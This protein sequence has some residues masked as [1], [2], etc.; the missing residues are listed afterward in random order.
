MDDLEVEG[1]IVRTA[2]GFQV[3]EEA[4]PYVRIVCA[5]FDAWLAATTVRHAPA[6]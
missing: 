3:P 2:D 6:V 4:A 5:R 1:L